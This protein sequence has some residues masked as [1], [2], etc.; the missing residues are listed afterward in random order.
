MEMIIPYNLRL[1]NQINLWLFLSHLINNFLYSD[2]SS[3]I[4]FLILGIFFVIGIFFSIM[5]I[6]FLNEEV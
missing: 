5:V 1:L 2:V 4:S 6:I 3:F